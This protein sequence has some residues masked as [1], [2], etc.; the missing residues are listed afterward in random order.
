[1]ASD[2]PLQGWWRS[3]QAWAGQAFVVGNVTIATLV[4]GKVILDSTVG[5]TQP[6]EFPETVEL[7]QWMLTTSEPLEPFTM[8]TGE[9]DHSLVG[10]RYTFAPD[11]VNIP[12]ASRADATASPSRTDEYTNPADDLVLT[13]EIR[14]MLET[15]GFIERL[16]QVH[17]EFQTTLASVEDDADIAA[18]VRYEYGVGH[19]GLF[20]IQDQTYLTACINPRGESTYSIDQFLHNRGI[21]DSNPN[22]LMSVLFGREVWQDNRCLWTHMAIAPTT[23]T[24]GTPEERQTRLEMAW[25]EWYQT[26]QPNFPAR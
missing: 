2:K 5:T 4:L 23:D 10:Q 1:M 22:R 16:L 9:S 26:W 20:Q 19:Y 7:D 6:F 18:A 21:Y 8:P 25:T 12:V 11:V 24:P 15:E 17:D 13:I 14:Y 3:R